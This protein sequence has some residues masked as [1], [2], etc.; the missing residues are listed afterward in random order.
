MVVPAN[1]RDESLV[2]DLIISQA[3][4]Y[5]EQLLPEIENIGI[6]WGYFVGNF[7]EKVHFQAAKE[8]FSGKVVQFPPG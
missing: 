7:V 2:E 5:F 8:G 4:L 1:I 6:G 3:A